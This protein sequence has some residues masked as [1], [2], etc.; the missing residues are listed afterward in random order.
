MDMRELELSSRFDGI[1]A[2]HSFFHLSHDDQELTLHKITEHLE[3]NGI[4]ILTVGDQYGESVGRVGAEEVYHA[5]FSFDTYEKILTS[6][7]MKVL[8]FVPNDPKCAK[9]SVL[10]A[11]KEI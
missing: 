8:E 5:S 6:L 7:N 10:L 11:Q 9:A 1:I 4:L 3:P 2:W